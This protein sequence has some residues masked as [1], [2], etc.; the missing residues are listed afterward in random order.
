MTFTRAHCRGVTY[1]RELYDLNTYYT[2]ATG[3]MG[4]DP[5][6][7]YAKLYAVQL[8]LHLRQGVW[9]SIRSSYMPSSTLTPT[10]RSSVVL[11]ICQAGR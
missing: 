5:L 3:G 1:G 11:G 2:Y 6:K 8:T 10:S 4:F 9:G 7:L